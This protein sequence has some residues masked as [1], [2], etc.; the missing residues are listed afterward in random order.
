MHFLITLIHA[1]CQ[2]H[3]NL[4]DWFS[5]IIYCIINY[6]IT[7]ICYNRDL[8]A[9]REAQEYKVERRQWQGAQVAVRALQSVCLVL[10]TYTLMFCRHKLSSSADTNGS[11]L[12]KQTVMFCWH[13]LLWTKMSYPAYTQSCPPDIQWYFPQT[14]AVMFC[15]HKF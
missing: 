1:K 12:L 9:N 11:V 4:F 15:W 2:A 8:K 3:L 5:Q 10:L 14:H 7:S 6:K 13:I